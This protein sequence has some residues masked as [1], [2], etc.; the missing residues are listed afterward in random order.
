MQ[1][2]WDRPWTEG[3]G[4]A[5]RGQEATS[6]GRGR[7]WTFPAPQSV[8]VRVRVCVRRRWQGLPAQ[9]GAPGRAPPPGPRSGLI[10]TTL[11]GSE[12]F[13]REGEAPAPAAAPLRGRPGLPPA[14]G[15][16]RP[17][18]AR[19]PRPPLPAAPPLAQEES[20]PAFRAQGGWGYPVPLPRQEEGGGRRGSLASLR[21]ADSNQNKKIKGAAAGATAVPRPGHPGW[22]A[23]VRGGC[24]GA[25]E[26]GGAGAGA[27]DAGKRGEPGGGRRPEEG[28]TR[29]P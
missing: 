5:F 13:A 26:A 21:R 1:L 9:P 29:P 4:K 6:L 16:G 14:R 15:R 3:T 8:R 10:R 18:D 19:V 20:N 2:A 22:C 25:G 11:Q 12:R 27:G 28:R 17:W 23:R 24:A 7:H